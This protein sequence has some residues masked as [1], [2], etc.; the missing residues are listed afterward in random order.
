[1]HYSNPTTARR[2]LK[3]SRCAG[4]PPPP[5]FRLFM[6]EIYIR[7]SKTVIIAHTS[8]IELECE[9]KECNLNRILQKSTGAS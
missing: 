5:R 3:F 6:Y 7:D 8:I 4:F 2:T 9:G 1:M